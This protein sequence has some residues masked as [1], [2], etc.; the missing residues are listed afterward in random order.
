MKLAHF[1]F[2]SSLTILLSGCGDNVI[3]HNTAPRPIIGKWTQ[4]S[5]QIIIGLDQP[6]YFQ[7]SENE[8]ITIFYIN[9]DE[10][11]RTNK[12]PILK[13]A[14]VD[15][16]YTV[17]CGKKDKQTIADYRYNISIEKHGWFAEISI[18]MISTRT[19]GDAQHSI[20]RFYKSLT[21]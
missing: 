10:G 5:D 15:R 13:I 9:E 12:L 8:L 21:D 2:L 20:G 1:S 17:F 7:I 4:T 14:N 11:Y 19:D 18:I 3:W 6:D 16:E